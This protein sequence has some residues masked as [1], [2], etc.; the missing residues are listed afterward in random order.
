MKGSEIFCTQDPKPWP[1]PLIVVTVI[2]TLIVLIVIVI[3]IANT[4]YNVQPVI[5][6]LDLDGRIANVI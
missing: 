5:P 3:V 1:W 6:A 2:S 4:R